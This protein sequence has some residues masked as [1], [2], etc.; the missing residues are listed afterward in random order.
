MKEPHFEHTSYGSIQSD[1]Q[2][3]KFW[4]CQA[5]NVS[6]EIKFKCPFQILPKGIFHDVDFATEMIN[7][8]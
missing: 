2:G 1:S 6:S 8:F 5:V 4:S 3:K 7:L